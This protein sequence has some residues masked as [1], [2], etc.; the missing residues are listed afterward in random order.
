MNKSS[1]FQNNTWFG[2]CVFSEKSI[3][4]EP[5]ISTAFLFFAYLFTFLILLNQFHANNPFL[6]AP[7]TSENYRFSGFFSGDID[8]TL[9]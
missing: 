1:T 9:A 2:L 4:K 6:H 7:K 5:D 3:T 8:V